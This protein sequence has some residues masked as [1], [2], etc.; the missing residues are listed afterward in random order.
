MSIH[1]EILIH[2][3]RALNAASRSRACLANLRDR[4]RHALL[5]LLRP[6]VLV[7]VIQHFS[8]LPAF[9]SVAVLSVCV[10]LT[11][12]ACGPEFSLLLFNRTA[13]L[14]GPI[15]SD[16]I[17]DSR[18]LAPAPKFKFT[19]GTGSEKYSIE[20]QKAR[21][22]VELKDLSADQKKALAAMR[23]SPD[24]D[25][26]YARGGT[27]PQAIRLYTAGAVDFSK[28]R[29]YMIDTE[30]E[31]EIDIE[32]QQ[33]MPTEA[34]D[35][36]EEC[37]HTR[38]FMDAESRFKAVLA[39]PD[40]QSRPRA[41]WAAFMLGRTLHATGRENAA[42]AAFRL[43]REL[44]S[45]AFPDPLALAEA[46]LG[47]E[48]FPYFKAKDY[49]HAAPLYAEQAAHGSPGG[50]NSLRMVAE[51][52]MADKGRLKE[53]LSDPLLQKLVVN[54]LL[55]RDEHNTV[56]NLS[57]AYNQGSQVRPSAL[58]PIVEAIADLGPERIVQADRL[59]ALA[60]DTGRYELA[61]R[62]VKGSDKPLAHWVNAKLAMRR[63]D[64]DEAARYY[65]QAAKAFPQMGDS[66]TGNSRQPH[67]V[68]GERATLLLSRGEYLQALTQFYAV[69]GKYW[70]D[71][72]YVAERVV[73][74]NELKAF[75]DANVPKHPLPIIE[76]PFKQD[77]ARPDEG[78]EWPAISPAAQL[79]DLLARRLVREG[80][81]EEAAP[82]FHEPADMRF[83]EG[84]HPHVPDARTAALSYGKALRD[85]A[86]AWIAPTRARKLF[87]AARLA[88]TEGMSIMGYE[89][90][91]DYFMASG[92]YQFE[93]IAPDPK[94]R[95]LTSQGEAARYLA[96]AAKPEKRF[97]YRYIAADLAL[98]SAENLP[99]RSQAYA[100]VLCSASS[101]VIKRDENKA[102]E[103]YRHYVKTGPH[104]PWANHFGRNCPEPKF[105]RAAMMA[106]ADQMAPLLQPIM[107][108]PRRSILAASLVV[109]LMFGGGW[110]WRRKRMLARS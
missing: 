48:A 108:H 40:A 104:V 6:R 1:R 39:L 37:P 55:D 22:E 25:I 91:P 49:R 9:I 27:L 105:N 98:R 70:V 28:G 20:P 96:S 67:L 58:G 52:V 29:E 54:Y 4:S 45:K 60:Y 18:R 5:V 84:D 65:A 38:L 59:A 64:S 72:A 81:F 102:M 69:G 53:N 99:R 83:A 107:K 93:E 15:G 78:A 11:A 61:T 75:V 21:Q 57:S 10:V 77:Y 94:G 16:F 7:R 92:S 109:M 8:R 50:S 47:E 76:R 44:A 97:H 100:A 66:I 36:G 88:R 3:R 80:R 24:G 79:R 82:Y 30:R 68:E 110:Y 34:C 73:T 13:T 90:A 95:A 85:A 87:E 14:S 56:E 31:R 103:I 46:S 26:A 32:H 62:L 33:K 63:G 17:Q 106:L 19:T 89:L 101:W 42:N 41:T 35:A 23:S 51:A 12:I 43:T 2:L 74:A 86:N 71:L